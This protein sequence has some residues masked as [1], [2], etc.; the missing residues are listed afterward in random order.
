[1]E[2]LRYPQLIPA[3]FNIRVVRTS[4]VLYH[5]FILSMDRSPGFGSTARNFRPFETRFR[6]GSGALHLNLA[7]Y[8]NS[9]ARST[10]STWS[11]SLPLLVNT[12]FQVLFHSPPGVLFTFPSRYCSSIG[13]QVVF[14]LGGWSPR[15]PTGF[16]VSGGTLDPVPVSFVFGYVALTLFDRPSHA[17][18]LTKS[19]FS[20]VLNPR[21]IATP[22]LASAA[23]ARHYLRYLF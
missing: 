19:T 23:F 15:L 2:F 14:R 7:A 10:K 22:G 9:P 17:V 11:L 18:P 16:H 3:F 12:G 13:H 1:M 20:T 21:N 4:T 5:R 8:S 6:F